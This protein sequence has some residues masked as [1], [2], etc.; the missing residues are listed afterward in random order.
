[1]QGSARSIP[2]RRLQPEHVEFGTIPAG[3]GSSREAGR[4]SGPAW[5]HPRGRGDVPARPRRAGSESSCSPRPRTW[6]PGRA[7]PSACPATIPNAPPPHATRLSWRPRSTTAMSSRPAPRSSRTCVNCGTCTRPGRSASRASSNRPTA[8]DRVTVVTG[9]EGLEPAWQAA[10]A[11]RVMYGLPR[12]E[13][14]LVQESVGGSEFSVQ[15]VTQHGVSTHVMGAW[16][17]GQ[18][19]S[20][21]A[22]TTASLISGRL[23]AVRSVT[24]RSLARSRR[25]ASPS[26]CSGSSSSA[27]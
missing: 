24:V 25:W 14:V 16:P 6:P 13:R 12:D 9:P 2:H 15:S 17:G 3:V 11:A 4:A 8:P 7:R 27:R 18:A 1:M 20:S 22:S 10:R 5:E 23:V 26:A 19:R 21:S